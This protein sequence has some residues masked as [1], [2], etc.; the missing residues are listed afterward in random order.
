MGSKGEVLVG[1]L[2]DEVLQKLRTFKNKLNFL[3][4]LVKKCT[5][6]YFYKTFKIMLVYPI[7]MISNNLT[8]VVRL[9]IHIV[10]SNIYY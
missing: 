9:L 3:C 2:G 4:I 10:T 5:E 6:I 7:R 8:R 1:G